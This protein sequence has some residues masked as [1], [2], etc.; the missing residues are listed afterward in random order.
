MRVT[1]ST[2]IIYAIAFSLTFQS[3]ALVAPHNQLRV[4]SFQTIDNGLL[5]KSTVLHAIETKGKGYSNKTE[6]DRTRFQLNQLKEDVKVAE[7]RAT[8][9]E[10]RVAM[11]KVAAEKSSG[12]AKFEKESKELKDKIIS[13]EKSLE[14]LK[15]EKVAAIKKLKLTKKK[16]KKK[17]YEEIKLLKE[18]RDEKEQKA[19]M[20]QNQNSELSRALSETQLSLN[21]AKEELKIEQENVNMLKQKLEIVRMSLTN[22]L[23]EEKESAR[24]EKKKILETMEKEISVRNQVIGEYEQER[25]SVRKMAKQSFKLV[26]SRIV[27][28]VKRTKQ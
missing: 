10:R 14:E 23:N 17:L 24:L 27:N 26:K 4:N 1:C 15:I 22:E 5:K 25:A 6:I 28:F 3:S 21:T 18:S 7:L 20:Y 9:A 2:L 19:D 13:Y 16:E 12:K 8:A 11:L